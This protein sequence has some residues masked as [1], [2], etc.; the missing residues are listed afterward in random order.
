MIVDAKVQ[1][2]FQN[3]PLYYNEVTLLLFKLERIKLP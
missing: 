1:L 2:S 3:I